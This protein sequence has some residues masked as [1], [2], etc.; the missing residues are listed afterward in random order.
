M[1][2]RAALLL[3]GL[4]AACA[5]PDATGPA[6]QPGADLF[7]PGSSGGSATSGDA[8]LLGRWERFDV[9]DAGDDIVSQT[10]AWEFLEDGR[11]R[12]TL[13]TFSAN[14]GVAREEVRDCTWS[15]GVASITITLSGGAP[16]TFDLSF[17]GFDPD[18]L[19]LDGLEYRRVA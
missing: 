1:T 10:T 18:R 9:L 19:V 5:A 13:E 12:R 14:E 11:C 15:T 7:P 8:A 6:L 4:L 16:A 2:A 17:A 3:V